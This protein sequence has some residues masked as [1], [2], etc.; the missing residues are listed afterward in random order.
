MKGALDLVTAL[1]VA[2]DFDA[3]WASIRRFLEYNGAEWITWG[4]AGIDEFGK[5]E[6]ARRNTYPEEWNKH[7]L[8]NDYAPHDYIIRHCREQT[9]P[10]YFGVEWPYSGLSATAEKI[11]NEV[12]EFECRSGFA[13]PLGRASTRRHAG[14]GFSNRMTRREF[15]LFMREREGFFQL[16][17]AYSHAFLQRH[18]I[19]AEAAAIHL[20]PREREALL[21]IACGLSSKGA[22]RKMNVTPKAI[23]FH[24]ANAMRKLGT[25]TRTHA[26]ARAVVLGLIEP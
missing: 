19:A 18:L 1:E 7:Y 8:R 11:R 24:L 13:I 10:L 2:Q 20:T 15:G 12:A 16:S 5:L 14:I 6:V 3:A 21:W 4:M 17:L 23:D 25:P 26:V 9:T 22:A